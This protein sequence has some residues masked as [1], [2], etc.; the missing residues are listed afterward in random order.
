MEDCR[1][2]TCTWIDAKFAVN[3]QPGRSV[4]VPTRPADCHDIPD[5]RAR[6]LANCYSKRPDFQAVSTMKMRSIFESKTD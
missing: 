2:A 5:K 3:P 1:S 4:L 6:V